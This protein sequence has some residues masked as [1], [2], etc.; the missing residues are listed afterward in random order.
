MFDQISGYHGP[1]TMTHKITPD[2]IYHFSSIRHMQWCRAVSII[3]GSA[4]S[5]NPYLLRGITGLKSLKAVS[6][7][8]IMYQTSVMTL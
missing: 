8:R 6:V 1:A 2:T 3:R 5:E 4:D 7:I